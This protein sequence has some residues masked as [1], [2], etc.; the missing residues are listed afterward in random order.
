M[1]CAGTVLKVTT[2]TSED[3]SSPIVILG[4]QLRTITSSSLRRLC[5]SFHINE[6]VIEHRSYGFL[7]LADEGF[8]A[9]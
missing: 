8:I 1:C 7:L 2:E 3:H 4:S 6:D 9:S 5:Y